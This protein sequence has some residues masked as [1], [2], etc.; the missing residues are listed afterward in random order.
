[1]EG[2]GGGHVPLPPKEAVTALKTFKFRALY[3]IAS[4]M[5]LRVY[6]VM[7]YLDDNSAERKC[8]RGGYRDDCECGPGL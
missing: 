4:F 6:T 7:H 8:G 3:D 5:I 2:G 1:M